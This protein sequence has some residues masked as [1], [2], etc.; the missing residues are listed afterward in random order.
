M[1]EYHSPLYG[2]SGFH[3]PHCQVRAQQVWYSQIGAYR[4]IFQND[5]YNNIIQEAIKF[6]S[7]PLEVSQCSNCKKPT[8]WLSRK[9]IYPHGQGVPQVNSDLPEDVKE[10]YLEAGAIHSL[11]PR[12]ACALLRLAIEM[13]LN[14]LGIKG[15]ISE[16]IKILVRE[17][18][19]DPHIKQALEIVRV[20]GNNAVH[21]GKIAFD[22]STE[23]QPLFE[24]INMI[25][26]AVITRPKRIQN[27][28]ESLPGKTTSK[29]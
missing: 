6:G 29:S 27:L 9:M 28:Y 7:D 17:R 11:S 24:L 23:A 8:L 21:P 5:R 18:G 10:V 22:D 14:H 19:V 12:A 20:T 1:S 2:S 26:D 3:C 15:R 16:G 4:I 13:L 25:A